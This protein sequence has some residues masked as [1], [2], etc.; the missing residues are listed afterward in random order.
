MPGDPLLSGI[1]EFE[2]TSPITLSKISERQSHSL[3]SVGSESSAATFRQQIDQR[4]ST[5]VVAHSPYSL[6]ASHLIPKRMGTDGVKEVVERFVRVLAAVGYH[7][8]HPGIGVL[9]F[10]GLDALVDQ[11]KL[12]FYH[13]T[14]RKPL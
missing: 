6:I 4:D 1:Y 7:I 12:G 5:C 8:F 3:T 14:V 9:L 2:T 10:S 13:V 11:Y